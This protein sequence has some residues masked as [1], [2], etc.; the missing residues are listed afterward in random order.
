MGNYRFQSNAELV[1]HRIADDNFQRTA[2]YRTIVK[3][4]DARCGFV[5]DVESFDRKNEGKCESRQ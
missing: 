4:V 5:S 1:L 3:L 2:Y